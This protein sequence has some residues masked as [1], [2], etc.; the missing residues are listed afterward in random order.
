MTRSEWLSQIEEFLNGNLSF[1]VFE[2]WALLH[3][4]DALDTHD[5]DVIAIMDSVDGLLLERDEGTIGEAEFLRTLSFVLDRFGW[6]A[7]HEFN[8]EG[9]DAGSATWVNE[10]EAHTRNLVIE[11]GQDQ[12]FH[13]FV[14]HK[15]TV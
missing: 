15:A 7:T 10:T 12:Y 13:L 2:S 4:Q 1:D 5:D 8:I 11:S 14:S 9:V 3:L 6:V